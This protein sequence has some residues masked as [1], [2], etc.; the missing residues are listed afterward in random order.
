MTPTPAADVFK[1]VNHQR[2]DDREKPNHGTDQR[3]MADQCPAPSTAFL[4]IEDSK[5]R[6]ER[7]WLPTPISPTLCPPAP[8][9]RQILLWRGQFSGE[10]RF[11]LGR[12][13]VVA[14]GGF[15]NEVLVALV[16][17]SAVCGG[18]LWD[19]RASGLVL[20]YC[21][22]RHVQFIANNKIY[23]AL[24]SSD[25][26]LSCCCCR[27]QLAKQKEISAGTAVVLLS[28]GNHFKCPDHCK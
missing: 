7:E 15:I 20:Y 1:W 25:F 12:H 2:R 22:P 27:S 19:N 21:P 23:H 14:R 8:W 16:A 18:N 26:L 4:E 17:Q 10:T 24:L 6:S 9:R 13:L 3:Q 28:S 5:A 11:W